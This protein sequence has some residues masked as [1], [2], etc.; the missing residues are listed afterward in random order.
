MPLDQ[1]RKCFSLQARLPSALQVKAEVNLW[2]HAFTCINLMEKC[3]AVLLFEFLLCFCSLF[4]Y[5]SVIHTHSYMYQ[6]AILYCHWFHTSFRGKQT[7]SPIGF[8]KL[9]VTQFE[10]TCESYK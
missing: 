7:N 6:L 10:P 5:I 2:E 9:G 8:R 3:T 4:T 1:N